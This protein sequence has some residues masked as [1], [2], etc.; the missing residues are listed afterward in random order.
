[1]FSS[2]IWFLFQVDALLENLVTYDKDNIH[3]NCRKAVQPYLADPEFDPDF[4]RSKSL[5]AGGLCSWVVNI[6]KYYEV[7]CEVEPKRLALAQAN[8]DLSA[9]REKLRIITNKI[10][11]LEA[12]LAELTAKFERATGEKLRCQQE[13]ESTAKTIELAN[14][15]VGGLASENVRWAEAVASFRKQE[16]TLPGDILMITA[17]VSYV[18]CFTKQYRLSLVDKYWLPFLG[19]LKNPIPL[20]EGLDPLSLLTDDATIASWNNQGLPSDRMSTENATIL[21]NC[22]RWP[23][24]IDPQLQ[25]IKWIKNRYGANLKIVRLGAKGYLDAIERAVSQGDVVLLE[26]IGESIDPVLDALLGRNTIKKG[27]AIKMGDKEVEYHI[28]FRL[29]LQ[30][31]LANPH[32]K[33]EMQAQTTL[34]NFTVT[35]DGL[36]DQLL[37]AVVSKERPDLEKLKSDLTRQQNQFKITLKELEDNLLA[38]LSAA[39]GNFLGDYALVENL[40]TTKRTAA[41][42]ELKSAEAKKTE[43]EINNA[44]EHY[45]P[46]AARASLLYFI[47]NDLNKINP[48]YQFSLKVRYYKLY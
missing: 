28:D 15:L 40:E 29:I 41:E 26:N 10:N 46:A 32:Y 35:R 45:R 34:I 17:F 38:R 33:P 7:F 8:A 5:A 3:E 30:T 23:L 22:E 24:M 42:I 4:I 11:A 36:E 37:A 43:V 48:M 21:T 13:A 2:R 1:M 6:I 14:R 31:K 19:T 20:S 47:L 44:R 12:D 18:G 39:Q 16:K 27:R 25:G 9:A